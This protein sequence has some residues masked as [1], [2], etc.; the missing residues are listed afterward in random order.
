MRVT[1]SIKELML[2]FDDDP[3][4]LQNNVFEV[5]HTNAR[6]GSPLSD[7]ITRQFEPFRY[8]QTCRWIG[9]DLDY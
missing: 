9:E 7:W 2:D 1:Q 3:V 5:E 6:C 8:H 4:I